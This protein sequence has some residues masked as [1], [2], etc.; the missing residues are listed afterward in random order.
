MSTTE[1]LIIEA[2]RLTIHLPLSELEWTYAR[3]GGPGGQNVNKV[4]SKAILR[5]DLSVTSAIPG[6]VKKRLISLAG[7]RIAQSGELIISSQ[8]FR[9]Q[10]KNRQA[11]LEKL[12]HLI[13]S[14]ATPPVQRIPTKPSKNAQ[15]RRVE[16]KKSNS[17]RKA[18]RRFTDHGD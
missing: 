3:S 18:N 9:D 13:L 6:W 11:C 17:L 1:A 4:S 2:D 15:L 7:K 10:E 8:N 14:A 12:R 16:D 5:W